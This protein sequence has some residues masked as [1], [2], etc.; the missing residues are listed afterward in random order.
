MAFTDAELGRL[1]AGLAE[2]GLDGRTAVALTADHGEEFLDHGGFE[3][4]HTLYGELVHVPL[5][6]RA[7]GLAPAR[8]AAGVGL[9]DVGPTLCEL[10]GLAP[11]PGASGTSL[12]ALV[13][14]GGAG[15]AGPGDRPVLAH[16]NFWGP[17]LSS[18]R[19][20]AEKLIQNAPG[21]ARALELYRWRE[22]PLEQR[23][24]AGQAAD[25]AR[26]LADELARFEAALERGEGAAVTLDEEHAAE[27]GELGYLDG[28]D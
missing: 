25:R 26:A 11:L 20:G 17:P 5:L 9:I 18:W 10:A 13:G 3:H 22:D 19:R 12:L 2:L 7:P 8:L 15:G 6:I 24:L 23:D 14:E 4:G 21:A 1:L 16:G 27:L 28:G